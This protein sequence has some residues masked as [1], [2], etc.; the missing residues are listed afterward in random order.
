[1]G[2]DRNTVIGFVL[3]AILLFLYLFISSKNSQELMVQRKAYEDSIANVKAAGQPATDIKV[4]SATA[5]AVVKDTAGFARALYGT[6]QD[7]TVDFGLLKIV[8]SSKGGQPRAVTLK[9]YLS[10]DKKTPVQLVSEA[11]RISYPVNT[12]PNQS[13][14]IADLNF[15]MLPVVA[16]GDSTLTVTYELNGPNGETLTHEYIVHKD[17]YAIDWNVRANGVDKLFTQRNLNINWHAEPMQHQK[18]VEYERQLANICFYEDNEFDY[19]SSNAEKKFEKPAHWLSVTQQF[20]S[21]ILLSKNNFT[22]GETH[23][24]RETSDTSKVVARA[25][26]SLQA[27]FPAGASATIPLQLYYGPNDYN[28]LKTQAPGMDRI[29]NLGR[30]MYSFVRPINVYIIMPVFNFFKKFVASY[31]VVILLLTLFIRLLTSPLVYKSYLSGAKMKVL[32][33]EMDALK[34]KFGD[35]QQGYGMAQMKLFREAGVNP[36]GGCIPALLQIPIFFALY[37]FFNSNIALRGQP[38]LWADDLSAYDSI[39]NL[40]F[41]IPFY[42]DHV[43]LF[44]LLAVVTSF[45][46]SW[47]GM[48]NAP[49]QNNPALKYM[50]YIF[51]VLLLGF[52]NKLPSALTWYYTVSNV[53]TLLL[54]WVI[55]HYIIDHDKILAKIEETRKKPKTK[56]KWQEKIEQMQNAQQNAQ[57]KTKLPGK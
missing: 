45:L 52:F 36:L 7:T 20:F 48:A 25:D 56:S 12:A 8:F 39:L 3:L 40:P 1:M 42:G 54:Q 41:T 37:S 44:T 30:D 32:R 43:S 29:V 17:N 34:Q 11:D 15:T 23:W 53:I 57:P 47:Y 6:R 21:T 38:F 14:Q 33:P 16:G 50:P 13:A 27:K 55:Q 4:D 10:Y 5:Q 22:S 35:D 28:Y 19:I 31:G 2:M 24:A 9:N 49:D 51:P 26:A 18:D 46:I